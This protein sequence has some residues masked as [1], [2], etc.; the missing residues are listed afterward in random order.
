M[1]PSPANKI[2]SIKVVLTEQIFSSV[3][4]SNIINEGT[5]TKLA[6]FFNCVLKEQKGTE[7]SLCI[8]L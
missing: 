8:K 3:Y 4:S 2:K 1:K 7:K 5:K 6:I